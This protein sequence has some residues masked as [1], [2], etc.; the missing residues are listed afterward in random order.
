MSE[1][2]LT[3]EEHVG[4]VREKAEQLSAALVA[5]TEAGVSPALIMPE[6]MAVFKSSGII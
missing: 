6:L 5:A 4:L 3:A 1:L 2:E